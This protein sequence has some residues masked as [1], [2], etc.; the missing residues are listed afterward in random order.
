MG[1]AQTIFNSIKQNYFS[2]WDIISL[3]EQKTNND[4]F[5][6][7]LFLGHINIEEHVTI[8][9]RDKFYNLHEIDLNF[10]RNPLGEIIDCLMNVLPFDSD[11]EQQDGR[12]KVRSK[13]DNLFFAKQDIYNFKPIMDL[14]FIDKPISQIIEVQSIQEVESNDRHK[15]FLYKQHLFSINECACIISDYDPLEIQKYPHDNI[16]EIAPDYSRAYSFIS[17]AIEANKLNIFNYKVGADD[18]RKYLAS[19]N[20]IISGFNDNFK[21]ELTNQNLDSQNPTIDQLKKENEKLKTELLEKEQKVKELEQQNLNEDIDLSDIPVGQLTGLS[22][23]NQLAQDRQ[24]MARIIALSLWKSD[25]TILIG[26]MANKV[27]AVMV[28]YCREELPD[29]SDTIKNWIRPVAKPQA[30]QR[31]RKPK[32]Q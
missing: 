9:V 14:G 7:G 12:I 15:F 17:S 3:I 25:E 27:Y 20:I 22:R 21:T 18:F 24:G 16:D 29:T 10:N 5:D 28:D 31:G 30:Q 11:E 32:N 23:R 2:V 8:Y 1:L 19:E 4:L 26:D 6:V 13:S